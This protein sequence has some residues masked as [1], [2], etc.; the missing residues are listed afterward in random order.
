MSISFAGLQS[1]S[2][3]GQPFGQPMQIA[4]VSGRAVRLSI[5]WLAYG[6][7]TVNADK[8]VNQNILVNANC[9][10]GAGGNQVALLDLVRSVYI[11]NS[12]SA[13][14]VFIQFPDTGFNVIASPYS[15]GWYP[16]FTNG[17][18]LNIA[19]FGFTAANVSSCLIYVTN[20]KVSAYTDT[21]LQSVQ[22]QELASP[23][24]GGGSS[25]SAIIP[26]PKGTSYN[27]GNLS[28]AGGGGS[29]GAAHGIL[30]TF[31]QFA[32]VV[33]DT[34]GEGYNALPVIAA[35]G[36]QTVPPIFSQNNTYNANVIVQYNNALW[37]WNRTSVTGEIACGANPWANVNYN[38]NDFVNYLGSIYIALE[39]LPAGGF[40]PPARPDL[41]SFV[42]TQFP[43]APS[44][45]TNGAPF[46]VAAFTPVLS[47]ASSSIITSGLGPPAL[48]DQA[49]NF[50]DT[51]TGANVFRDNLFGT[52]ALSGFIYLTHINVNALTFNAANVW[53][54]Q[55]ALG[56]APFA[57]SPQAV[58]EF[59]S[60]QKMNM[61]LDATVDWQLKCTNFGGNA[62]VSHA[63]AWTYSQV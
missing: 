16:V 55:N 32:S 35:T 11:D 48:G 56:Y 22:N 46:S 31:G 2:Y 44:W 38:K 49:A 53:T 12:G 29:A 28:I 45:T 18:I 9:Q 10:A 36:G 60:L 57:F 21:S 26:F 47:A 37:L 61:K 63:F 27:N 23:V 20:V 17:F 8:T 13:L 51:I 6:A 62:K 42:G 41:W 4:G 25:I 43:S 15:T 34:P 40:L 58:G 33:V 1:Q 14:P 54:L 30:D 7:G 3:I 52:P 39:T 50:I 5:N 24:L 19:S 59:M